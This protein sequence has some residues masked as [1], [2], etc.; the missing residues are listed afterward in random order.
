MSDFLKTIPL[1]QHTPLVHF[2]AEQAG[3]VLR[4]TELKPAIDRL[5]WEQPRHVPARIWST[6]QD[7]IQ[8]KYFNRPQT[9]DLHPSGYKIR[10]TGEATAWYVPNAYM[11]EEDKRPLIQALEQHHSSWLQNGNLKVLANGPYMANVDKIEKGKWAEV[12]LA[13]SYANVSVEVFSPTPRLASFVEALMPYVLATHNFGTRGSKGFG[14]F[15]VKGKENLVVPSLAR[16]WFDVPQGRQGDEAQLLEQLFRH[17]HLT[18]SVLRAGINTPAGGGFYFKS[19]LFKYFA[20]RDIQWEKKTIKEQFY[21]RKQDD[22]RRAHPDGPAGFDSDEKYLVRDLLGLSSSQSWG[23]NYDNDEVSKTNLDLDE[24]GKVKIARYASPI[25]FCP[26]RT[27][28]GF[29]VYIGANPVP[30]V[31]LDASFNIHSKLGKGP[32]FSLDTP[33]SFDVFKFLDEAFATDL[34]EHVDDHFHH[35]GDFKKLVKIFEQIQQQ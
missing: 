3:A 28:S 15:G 26:I 5:V 12:R 34:Y 9:D 8:P 16:Y 11:K 18:Y 35:H 30:D 25:W 29:R 10:V 23:R 24:K 33:P 6:Y 17:I 27:G 20:D 19:L 32:D 14:H 4:A 21:F 22:H 2:Q 31:M 13:V 1:V 7:L